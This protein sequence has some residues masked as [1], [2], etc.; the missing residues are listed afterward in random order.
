MLDLINANSKQSIRSALRSI[1]GVFS[2]YILKLLKQ[3]TEIRISIESIINFE[4][5]NSSLFLK[6]IEI[7]LEDIITNIKKTKKTAHRGNV[8]REGLK[9]TIVGPPNSGKSSLFNALTLK[10]A[11]IV[12]KIKGTTRDVL[13]E[14]INVHGVD[15]FF[16]DTAG[17]RTTRNKIELIGIQKT[18][19]EIHNSDHILLVIDSSLSKKKQKDIYLNF[20]KLVDFKDLSITVLLNKSDLTNNKTG[21]YTDKNVD[22]IFVSAIK[23]NRF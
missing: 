7:K 8:L 10:D 6:T 2:S 17:L 19:N 5:V 12:T 13:R 15:F 14:Q 11:A 9:I 20:I 18:Y 4:E 23:K 1:E 22:Y 21:I 3:I 16:S